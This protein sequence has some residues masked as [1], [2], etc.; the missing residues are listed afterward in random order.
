MATSNYTLPLSRW[1]HVADRIRES[2]DR[3]HKAAIQAL[4]NTQLNPGVPLDATQI[5][6]LKARGQ[7]ALEQAAEAR[8]ALE[9]VGFIRQELAR[10]NAEKGITARLAKAE[11]LRRVIKQLGEYSAIDLLTRVPVDNI[12]SVAK[13]AQGSND[14][15]GR[16]AGLPV[17]LVSSEA[18]DTLTA[19]VGQ[20]EAEVAA[21]T[22]EIAD[23][24]R[25]TLTLE[26]PVDLAKAAGL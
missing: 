15:Y 11:A 8:L 18:L 13:D 23:L 2:G 5:Q 17:A 20:L 6:A 12:G 21:I 25:T 10:V 14:L 16:R 24:N 9:T 1:H 19:D 26:L 4:G 22:D 3:K 7:K